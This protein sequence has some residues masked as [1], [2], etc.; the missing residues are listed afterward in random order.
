MSM[1]RA[2]R[3]RRGLTLIELIIAIGIGVTVIASAYGCSTMAFAYTARTPPASGPSRTCAR[4][5]SIF[6]ETSTGPIP[7]R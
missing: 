7:M 4:W 5:R 3:N 6:P 2:A 1:L